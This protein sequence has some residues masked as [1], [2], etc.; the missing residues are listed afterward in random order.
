MEKKR[1]ENRKHSKRAEKGELNA[2]KIM[3]KMDFS[4]C[5]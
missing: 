4:S 2:Y 5:R 1:E 3:N